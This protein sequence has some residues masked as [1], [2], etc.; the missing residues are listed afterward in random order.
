MWKNFI[1]EFIEQVLKE[2]KEETISNKECNKEELVW[3]EKKL[4]DEQLNKQDYTNQYNFEIKNLSKD[5]NL[6]YKNNKSMCKIEIK[7]RSYKKTI[8]WIIIQII[9]GI[10]LITISYSYLQNHEA[11]RKFFSSSIQYWK[12]L[13]AML[14]SKLWWK[15]TK[16]IDE[17]YIQKRADMVS[18]LIKL[19]SELDECIQREKNKDTLKDLEKTKNDVTELKMVLSNTSY[20]PLDK[21]I[22]KYQ[23]YS[24]WVNSLKKWVDNYCKK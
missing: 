9:L 3:L 11:E 19:S 6:N 4:N 17:D 15:F 20:L 21:F 23:Y 2:N 16:Q 24:L 7:E 10:T 1:E 12:N 18:I 13:G 5:N 14:Y 22:E 8:I